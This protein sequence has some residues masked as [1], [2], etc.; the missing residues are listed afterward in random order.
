MKTTGYFDPFPEGRPRIF[1]HRG[2]TIEGDTQTRDENTL[3]AFELAL[4]AGADY[5]ETDIQ[6]TADG[7]PVLFHD[8]DLFRLTGKKIPIAKFSMGE[9]ENV[10]LPLGGQIP[11]LRSALAEFPEARFNFDLKS[12]ATELPAL[13]AIKDAGA[14]ERVLVSSFSERSRRRALALI[15]ETIATSA[16]SSKVLRSVLYSRIGHSRG[17]QKAVSDVDALQLPLSAY[18]IDFTNPRFIQDVLASDIELHYWVINDPKQMIE[19]FRL[20]AH[21]IVTDRADLAARA[22]S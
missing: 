13:M 14:L 11:T 5:L 18:G 2:L 21:G 16:G 10:R 7:V 9:L 22:F 6:I 15:S 4:S 1:A 8:R 12:P 17:F 3:G 20:G 19:L